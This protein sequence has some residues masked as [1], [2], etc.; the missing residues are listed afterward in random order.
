[1]ERGK[2]G[3]GLA[4]GTHASGE[5]ILEGDLAGSVRKRGSWLAEGV[6]GV[7]GRSHSP[8][9][10]LSLSVASDGDPALG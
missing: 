10:R 8:W 7:E 1:M 5:A 4:R 9:H 3:E 2:A 6:E